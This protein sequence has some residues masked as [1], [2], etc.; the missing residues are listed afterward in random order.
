MLSEPRI[1]PNGQA[2]GEI[3]ARRLLREIA[4]DLAAQRERLVAV[5]EALPVSPRADVMLLDEESADFSTEAR[6]TIECAL[7]DHLEPLIR[8]LRAAADYQPGE[9]D[10]TRNRH[11]ARGAAVAGDPSLGHPEAQDE[12]LPDR[13]GA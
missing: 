6:R 1:H 5:H 7:V 10:E 4:A 13:A 3:A 2:G 9:E 12:P 8:I 11:P